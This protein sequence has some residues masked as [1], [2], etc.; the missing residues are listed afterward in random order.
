MTAQAY[1]ARAIAAL[2][3]VA[4]TQSERLGE[5]AGLVVDAIV[6]GK[7]LYAFGA[8][9]SFMVAEELVYRT[10]G[11]MLVNPIYPHGMNLSVRPIPVTS[12]LERVA[13][14]GAELLGQAPVTSGDVVIVASTSGRNPVPIDLALA[15]V[16]RG[17][18]VIGITSMAY[19]QGVSSRHASG[20]KLLD[21]CTVVIDNGAPY[22]DAAV[23]VR[24]FAQAVG[25]LSSVTGCAIAN[26]IVAET[27]ARLVGRG[28]EPPV[29][30]SAN[31]DGGDAYNARLMRQN[32]HRIHYLE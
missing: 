7:A 31:V 9:H 6:G 14:L 11:L 15:A 5:A 29:F 22:G 18:K 23:E 12:Q 24:G 2:E 28:Y 8:T 10:G 4:A 21:V 13:G 26:A 20:K 1:F 32:A 16:A 30:M 27:V 3:Q 19:T 17:A 25:P